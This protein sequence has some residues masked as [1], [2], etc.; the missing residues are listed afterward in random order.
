MMRDLAAARVGVPVA[1]RPR[2]T[3]LMALSFFFSALACGWG[4]IVP[5]AKRGRSRLDFGPRA[6][7]DPRG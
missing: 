7:R 4:S 6:V 1:P 3:L 5:A 2:R